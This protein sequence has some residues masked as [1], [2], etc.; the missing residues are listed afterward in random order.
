MVLGGG[1]GVMLGGVD[2]D[3]VGLEIG[4]GWGMWCVRALSDPG[5]VLS[6]GL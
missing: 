5:W 1:V 2:C 4:L 3:R 6:V